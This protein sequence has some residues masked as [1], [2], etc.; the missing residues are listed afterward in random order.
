MIVFKNN[1]QEWEIIISANHSANWRSILYIL[2]ALGGFTLLIAL[3]WAIQGVWFILPFACLEVFLLGFLLYKVNRRSFEKQVIRTDKNHIYL[4]QG[5]NKPELTY[6]F[7]RS[8]S[9]FTIT[10]A[11]HSLSPST[12]SLSQGEVNCSIGSQLNKDDI[13]QMI[14]WVKSSGIAY[15]INGKTRIHSLDTFE[16]L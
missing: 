6:Q 1:N 12:L 11:N 7:T 8:Q 10:H 5:R 14:E 3:F 4:E 15:K 9:L 13:N 2:M 16:Q